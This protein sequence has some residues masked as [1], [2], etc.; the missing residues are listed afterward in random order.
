MSKTGKAIVF[1]GAGKPLEEREY[2]IPE[3]EP[4]AILV[5]TVMSTVC[6]S[7]M[8]SWKGHRPFPTPSILGH[9]ITG[10][11]VKLGKGVDRDTAGKPLA[12]GDRITWTIMANCG[13]C[14]FCRMKK[15]P[16]KCLN[17]F[18]YGHMSSAEPPYF[19]GGFAEYVYIR[20]GTCVFKVPDEL[21]D[22]EAT[23]LNCAAATVTAGLDRIGIDLGDNAV[24]QGDGMLGLYA[25]AMLKERGAGKVIVL[26][27]HDERLRLAEELG[28]D[29]TINTKGYKDEDL[30]KEVRNLVGGW[31]SDLVIEVTGRADAVPLGVKILRV[32]GRYLLLGFVS[33]GANF[34]ID[35]CDIVVNCL[36][37]FGLHNYDAEHLGKALEFVRKTRDKYPFKKLVGPNFELSVSG[38]TKA[39]EALERRESLR[40]AIVM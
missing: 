37:M 10:K 7:D 30:V 22:E 9:E 25:T 5:K 27:H 17:L 33:P 1:L 12:E 8:H 26:G 4:G 18:K 14:F 20:P 36:T 13:T 31:G 24:V 32:G 34:T 11:I 16:Q 40:P 2:P 38:V 3:V 35:G 15:L 28:A 21:L 19:N 23:P 39:L 29:Y 6:G